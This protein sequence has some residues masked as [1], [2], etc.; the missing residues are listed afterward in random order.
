MSTWSAASVAPD[1]LPE[2]AVRVAGDIRDT[3]IGVAVERGRTRHVSWLRSCSDPDAVFLHG[4]SDSAETWLPSLARL[5]GQVGILAVDARGHGLSA[6]PNEPFGPTAMADDVA[7][8]L[9]DLGIDRK[10]TVVGGSM[11]G[12]TAAFLASR[13]P[14]LVAAL[15]LE[16]PS[17]GPAPGCDPGSKMTRPKWLLEMQALDTAARVAWARRHRPR[18]PDDELELWA[19]AIGQVD[20]SLHDLAWEPPIWL[21]DIIRSVS[22]PI[23]FIF[24]DPAHGSLIGTDAGHACIDGAS[25]GSVLQRLPGIGHG[26]HREARD[27]CLQ[28]I[29][30]AIG[31]A[32]ALQ[33]D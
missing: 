29:R 24:G 16:E 25:T 1:S 11:G 4:Y 8:V 12:R 15:V 28:T 22:C 14:D 30:A 13:R 31:R 17:L 20:L 19:V 21:P 18:W 27:E 26:V 33:R 9:D 6:L 5:G 2:L 32:L 7:L 3:V 10:V 23:S